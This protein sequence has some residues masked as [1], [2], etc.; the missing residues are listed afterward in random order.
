MV[1]EEMIILELKTVEKL[2]KILTDM[3]KNAISKDEIDPEETKR[4]EELLKPFGSV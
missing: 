1:V 4:I 2:E 3:R